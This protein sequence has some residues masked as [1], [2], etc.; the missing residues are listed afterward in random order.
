M[1][2]KCSEKLDARPKAALRSLNFCVN[3]IILVAAFLLCAGAVAGAQNVATVFNF[4]G[5]TSDGA[6]PREGMR[7]QGTRGQLYGATYN[8]RE[9]GIGTRVQGGTSRRSH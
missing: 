5:G 4:S 2:R 7:G 1:Q 3:K 9:G 8:G 6:K